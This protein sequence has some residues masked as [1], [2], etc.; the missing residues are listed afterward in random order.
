MMPVRITP[1]QTK[2]MVSM[3]KRDYQAMKNRR[4]IS[5]TFRGKPRTLDKT[6]RMDFSITDYSGGRFARA[7]RQPQYQE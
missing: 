2:G 7:P 6:E 4:R 3:E 5:M 1:P